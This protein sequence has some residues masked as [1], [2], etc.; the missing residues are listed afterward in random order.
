M[1]AA[2]AAAVQ[3]TDALADV[4]GSL[5]QLI[6]R[7]DEEQEMETKHKE[8]CESEQSTAKVKKE[9]HEGHVADLTQKIADETEVIAEKTQALQDTA[10]SIARADKNFEEMTAIRQSEKEAFDLELQNFKDA[11]AALNQAIDILAKHYSK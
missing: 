1:L 9:T 10:D 3:G 2:A 11:I 6:K 4:I 7:I 5:E 8:W